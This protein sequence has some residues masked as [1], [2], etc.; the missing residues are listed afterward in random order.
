MGHGKPEKKCNFLI[1]FS[2]PEKSWILIVGHRK[3][4]K[5]MF[6]EKITKKAFF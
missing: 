4:L 1:S 6:M 2:R 3:S 5:M